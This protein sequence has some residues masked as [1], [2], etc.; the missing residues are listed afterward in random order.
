MTLPRASTC[1]TSS[2]DE[3]RVI[4]RKQV[5][6]GKRSQKLINAMLWRGLYTYDNTSHNTILTQLSQKQLLKIQ[7]WAFTGRFCYF[8]T[9]DFEIVVERVCKL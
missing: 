3:L 1:G 6:D 4:I 7:F 2:P 9:F 5:C 8:G